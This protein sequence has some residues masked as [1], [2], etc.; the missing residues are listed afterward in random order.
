M[1]FLKKAKPKTTKHPWRWGLTWVRC[2]L[3]ESCDP[4]ALSPEMLQLQPYSA[5]PVMFWLLNVISSGWK[6]A[7][8]SECLN[9]STLKLC[10]VSIKISLE[11][12]WLYSPYGV[13]KIMHHMILFLKDKLSL[14]WKKKDSTGEMLIWL[15]NSK[16]CYSKG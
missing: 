11:S 13:I 9:F 1:F 10:L 15:I 12:V 14:F 3:M 2:R 7:A 5:M 6:Y 8:S 4:V 16:F